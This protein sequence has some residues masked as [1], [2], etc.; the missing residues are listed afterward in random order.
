MDVAWEIMEV[1]V[2]AERLEERREALGRLLLRALRADSFVSY[3]LDSSGP[4][5][6]P[7]DVNLGAERLRAYDT[8]YRHID[9]LTPRM[10]RMGKASAITLTSRIN[11]EFAHD[12]LYS[13]GMHHGLNYFPKKPEVGSLDLRVWRS[14]SGG[15]FSRDDVRMLQAVGDVVHRLWE[16]P[17]LTLMPLTSREHEVARLV[18]EGLS[19][20]AICQSLGISLPT[21]RT[22]LTHAFGKTGAPN[23][24]ALATYVVTHRHK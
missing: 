11:D 4:Y 18:A 21:L 2:S 5:A 9:T 12:F 8:H 3:R 22:H 10:L 17:P 16:D 19:D 23:R 1:A 13:S 6:D 24:A 20:R 15:S 14:Q 7:V